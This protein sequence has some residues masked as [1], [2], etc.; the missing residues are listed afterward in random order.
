M[1]KEDIRK[2]KNKIVG[3]LIIVFLSAISIVVKN[4]LSVPKENKSDTSKITIQQPV[5]NAISK[6]TSKQINNQI[7][8]TN[9]NKGDVNNEFISGNKVINN[10]TVIV[11]QEK[12]KLRVVNKSD[13]GK[14][15]KNG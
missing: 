14:I 7:I 1:T 12:P 3:G 10:K 2:H 15:L 11:K 5:I 9:Q 8:Q 13:I 6:D 4:A